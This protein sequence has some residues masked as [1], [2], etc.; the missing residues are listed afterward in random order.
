MPRRM[1]RFD[2]HFA[3]EAKIAS[4][5]VLAGE[6]ARTIVGA[7]GDDWTL[8]RLEF[9]YEFAYLRVFAAWEATLEAIFLRSLCGYASRAGQ[10]TL[11]AGAYYRSVDDAEAAVLAAE[12]HGRVRTYLLWHNS[13]QIINR[14]NRHIVSGPPP[15]LAIQ[16]AV[17]ASQFAHLDALAAIRHRIVHDQ[18]DAKTK[19][20]TVARALAGRTYPASRPGKFLRDTDIHSNPRRKSLDTA[21][22][23]L[24]GLVG[25]MV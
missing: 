2:L 23:E 18:W 1:P 7:T 9:L 21:I 13:T 24:T 25:Q 17:I 15:A 19:F 14:C 5:I 6:R 3:A 22:A 4:E 12:G 11:V 16:E 10:E 20:D 8:K